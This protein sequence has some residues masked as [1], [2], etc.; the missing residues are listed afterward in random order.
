MIFRMLSGTEQ[1]RCVYH[2]GTLPLMREVVRKI[3]PEQSNGLKPGIYV[4]HTCTEPECC[5]F[6]AKEFGYKWWPKDS[7]PKNKS[8]AEMDRGFCET[9]RFH[10]FAKEARPEG[11][12]FLCPIA[13]CD[14]VVIRGTGSRNL[15]HG[16]R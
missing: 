1:P 2:H 3:V 7:A 11:I 14:P 6:W 16:I 13:G 12:T 15:E 10:R 5:G 4:G 8:T 9:H